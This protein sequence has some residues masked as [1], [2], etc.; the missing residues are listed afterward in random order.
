LVFLLI[1]IFLELPYFFSKYSLSFC[2]GVLEAI[3]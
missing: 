2:A 3:A 1:K